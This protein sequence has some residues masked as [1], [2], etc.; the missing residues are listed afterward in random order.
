MSEAQRIRHE[1][2]HAA[3]DQQPPGSEPLRDSEEFL[4]QVQVA[5]EELIGTFLKAQPLSDALSL[6]WVAFRSME[7]CRAVCVVFVR[8]WAR[9]LEQAAVEVGLICPEC[10]NKR[11]ICWRATQPLWVDLLCGRLGIGKPYLRCGVKD[12]SGRPL[13][14]TRLLS[15]LR[16]GDSGLVLKRQAGRQGAEEGY[17]KSARSLEEHPLG[18]QRERG[19]LRR[20]AIEV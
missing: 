18:A 6:S 19:K 1:M 16:S 14:V 3:S 15:G 9:L 7:L 4:A 11:K 5:L 13:S 12:C 20:L 8:A 10:G 2:G 17:G